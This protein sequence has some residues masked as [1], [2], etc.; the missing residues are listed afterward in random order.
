MLLVF[1]DFGVAWLVFLLVDS[2]SSVGRT[3]S[4]PCSE[5]LSF[6]WARGVQCSFLSFMKGGDV[7]C[8]SPLLM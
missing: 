7:T 1:L 5:R 8:F 6:H 2:Q 3:V 4:L